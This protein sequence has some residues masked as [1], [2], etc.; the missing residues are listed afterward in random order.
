MS[1]D[2]AGHIAALAASDQMVETAKPVVQFLT[3]FRRMCIAGGFP[4]PL[5]DALVVGAARKCGIC[6]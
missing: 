4:E 1:D 2:Q 3:E 6:A 5:A